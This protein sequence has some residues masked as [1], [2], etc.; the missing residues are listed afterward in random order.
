MISLEQIEYMLARRYNDEAM[1]A[2]TERDQVTYELLLNEGNAVG[3]TA[4]GPTEQPGEWKLH[5][6]Y[7]LPQWQGRGFGGGLMDH[8]E[9][10]AR[11]RGRSVVVLT[12]NRRNERARAAYERRGYR[13][14]AEACV[15]IGGGFVMDDFVMTKVVG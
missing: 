1:R 8:V 10:V 4:H 13:V 12:V 6:L 9:A 2:A 3:F 5:Q 11:Q 14:R 15:D 7:I